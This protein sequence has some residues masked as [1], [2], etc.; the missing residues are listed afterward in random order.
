MTIFTLNGSVRAEEWEA[1]LMF[2]DL[3]H[4]NL[5]AKNRVTLSAVCTVLAPVN[6]RMAIRAVFAYVG[7]DWLA[8]TFDAFHIFVQSPQGISGLVVIEFGNHAD[9]PPSGRGV[10]IFT[11]DSERAVGALSVI[12][13]GEK[14]RDKQ[15]HAEN[16]QEPSTD[17]G[18]LI[19]KSP[20]KTNS[21]PARRGQAGCV[22]FPLQAKH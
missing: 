13:L 22:K 17:L 18:T 12:F 1:I 19:R 20:I 14:R 6:V 9:R 16:E 11:R 8:V 21:L 3:R 4:R 2:L 10:A 5:P 7:K 15:N